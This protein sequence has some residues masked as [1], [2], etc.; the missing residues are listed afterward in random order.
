M[1]T[2][3]KACTA[4][5]NDAE[6]VAESLAGHRD[7]FRQIVERHQTLVCSLAYCATGSLTQ[8]ED[9]AQETFLAAWRQLAE[10]RE[11][12]KL[13]PWLCGI[14]RFVIGK[15][16]RRQGHE[17]VHAAAALETVNELAAPEPLPSERVMSREE[18]AILWHCVARIPEIY[19]EPLVLFYREHQSIE[20]VAGALELSEDVVKQRLARGRKLLQEQAL[21]YVEGALQNTNP[22]H[23]LTVSVL[24]ALPLSATSAKVLAAGA[25]VKGSSTAKTVAGLAALGAIILFYSLLGFLAF[26]GVCAGYGMG[27]ACA[28]SSRQCENGIRFWRT[29]AISCVVFLVIPRW[30]YE[31]NLRH[32]FEAH[33]PGTPPLYKIQQFICPVLFY[34]LAVAALA[35][36][37]WRWWREWARREADAEEPGKLLKKRF[38]VWLSLG[39]IGPAYLF[40]P[41]FGTMLW[42]TFAPAT[43]QHLSDAEAQQIIT[44]R[45]D[46]QF[47]V[48]QELDGTKTLYLNLPENNPGSIYWR[49]VNAPTWWKWWAEGTKPAWWN[50]WNQGTV[51]NW[52]IDVIAWSGWRPVELLAAANESTLR[53]LDEEK[54]H[55]ATS[56]MHQAVWREEWKFEWMLPFLIA[57]MGMTIL[58]RR[59]GGCQWETVALVSAGTLEQ[60][61]SKH[62]R[63]LLELRTDPGARRTFSIAFAAMFLLVFS[64]NAITGIGLGVILFIGAV[65]GAF[66]GLVAGICVL[67][68]RTRRK[69][70]KAGAGI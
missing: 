57:P 37:M 27:R 47:C 51:P 65:K 44:G 30:F 41:L 15:E 33:L 23:A 55:Y 24:A 68:L 17:P 32:R 70:S 67:Y 43:V 29:L 62:L 11:P 10:L 18:E 38:V 34:A 19:R 61:N 46:A 22:G 7:A 50:L 69:V 48:A 36:W 4:E 2:T 56:R 54:I 64:A 5:F 21:A 20:R 49:T 40:V 16:L 3:E 63:M 28:R 35:I 9:L 39:M 45:N 25:A 58:L 42:H 26:V 59:I 52:W 60:Q 53:L 14:T 66:L 12:S 6:L 8:S 31:L 1:M 13:R